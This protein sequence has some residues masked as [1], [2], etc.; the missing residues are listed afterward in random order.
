MRERE[1]VVASAFERTERNDGWAG[2]NK[3]RGALYVVYYMGG[4][5]CTFCS[6][7][8]NVFSERPAAD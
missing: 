4:N 1:R 6:K 5:Q 3:S 8:L 2:R 7:G